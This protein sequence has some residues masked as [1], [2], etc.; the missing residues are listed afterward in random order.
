MLFVGDDLYIMQRPGLGDQSGLIL[1][2]NNRGIWNGASVQTRWNNTRLVP[3]PQ[4][5][6]DDFG[7]PQEK[8]TT[9]RAGLICG[10]LRA[11]MQ[12]MFGISRSCRDG[13]RRR[14][15]FAEKRRLCAR[16][17]LYQP[18]AKLCCGT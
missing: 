14:L 11:A 4:R 18:H 15:V 8:W 7:V 13:S 3:A 6:R 12:F 5:A 17:L 9:T 10:R 2:L 16:Y 1:V